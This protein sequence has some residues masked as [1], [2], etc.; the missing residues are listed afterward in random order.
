[1]LS[2]PGSPLQK[3]AANV[4]SPGPTEWETYCG[5]GQCTG[6]IPCNELRCYTYARHKLVSGI[7]DAAFPT[8]WVKVVSLM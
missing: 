4:K 5:Q 6:Y 1:M 7:Q 8:L 2:L 3:V